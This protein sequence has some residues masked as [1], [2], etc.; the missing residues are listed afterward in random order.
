MFYILAFRY[1]VSRTIVIL[2]LRRGV[3][4]DPDRSRVEVGG[5]VRAKFWAWI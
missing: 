4:S 5:L 2:V 1:F 3:V